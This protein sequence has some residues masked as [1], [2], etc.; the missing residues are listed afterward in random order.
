MGRQ[1]YDFGDRIFRDALWD[2]YIVPVAKWFMRE[3]GSAYLLPQSSGSIWECSLAI[4]FLL[5]ISDNPFT[6]NVFKKEINERCRATV[7]WMISQLKDESNGESS[8]WDSAIWDTAVA[9]CTVVRCRDTL[10]SMSDADRDEIDS[11]AIKTCTWLM[12]RVKLWSNDAKYL[13]GPSDLAKVLKAL[14]VIHQRYTSGFR[15]AEQLV[16]FEDCASIDE[17]TRFLV[18]MAISENAPDS[19]GADDL[20]KGCLMHWGGAFNTGEVL[21]GLSAY[22]NWCSSGNSGKHKDAVSSAISRGL[23]YVETTQR[24]GIWNN[25]PDTCGTLWCYLS[26]VRETDGFDYEDHVVFK[27]MR[28]LC[29]NTQALDDGSF[30]HSSYVTVFYALALYEAYSSWPLGNKSTNEV[31]DVALW[32]AP[33]SSSEERMKRLELELQ[34]KDHEDTLR[35]NKEREKELLL[36]RYTIYTLIMSCVLLYFILQI[37]QSLIFVE[38]KFD[39]NDPT[40]LISII[41]IWITVVPILIA[42]VRSYVNKRK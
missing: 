7:R 40:M 38:W 12:N 21:Q 4:D 5:Q 29:D 2:E 30:L 19:S 23:R 33:N 24:E 34:I 26:V 39:V 41:G 32:L 3:P 37:S 17:A 8:S 36:R 1:F 11:V 31:Y 18:T 22:L 27:A 15:T 35:N 16:G 10:T 9:L 25:A 6:E 28:G 42:A 13:L 14:V 20:T